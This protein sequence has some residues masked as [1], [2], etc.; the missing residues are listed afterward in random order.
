M[1]KRLIVMAVLA[2]VL[3]TLTTP[4]SADE[5][6]RA[7]QNVF[8]T[9]NQPIRQMGQNLC[10]S[11]E[12]GSVQWESWC[13][14]RVVNP[15][16]G[17]VEGFNPNSVAGQRARGFRADELQRTRYYSER[18]GYAGYYT[19]H[20]PNRLRRFLHSVFG[21]ERGY[22]GYGYPGYGWDPYPYGTRPY[23][24]ETSGK[25]FEKVAKAA[26]KQ[27]VSITAAEIAAFC[28]GQPLPEQPSESRVSES[29]VVPAPVPPPAPET[30]PVPQ[31]TAQPNP[32]PA[33]VYVQ[34]DQL[35]NNTGE[36]IAVYVDDVRVGNLK[37]GTV[38]SIS[39][40]R[41]LARKPT[42]KVSYY[43]IGQ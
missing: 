28:N 6:A 32:A 41:S 42:G 8:D 4:V 12:P 5:F 36:T 18:G 15:T 33:S 3:A 17:R 13:R 22:Y 38:A 35:C 2:V 11:A 20:R 39:R 24:E 31:A 21:P 37:A 1:T 29:H 19:G 23:D 14:G 9:V 40:L 7:Y 34:G 10:D 26:K 25:C 16:T 30:A 43:P 27:K